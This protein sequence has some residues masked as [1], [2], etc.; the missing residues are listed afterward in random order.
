MSVSIV[1]PCYNES[2]II[3]D[4]VESF[5]QEVITKI[6]ESELIIVDDSSNDGS[7]QIL[8]DLQ[9][10]RPKLRVVKTDKNL[11]HGGA[12]LLGY[13]LSRYEYVFQTD[14]DRQFLVE[15][16]WKFYAARESFDFILGYRKTRADP[17]FR[18]ILSKFIFCFNLIVFSV[19]V[20][21]A[22]CAFRLMKK[23][24]LGDCL[25]RI[26]KNTLAPNIL[27]SILMKKSNSKML[28]VPLRHFRRSG[29]KA[30]F[31]FF[32]VISFALKGLFQLF[33]FRFGKSNFD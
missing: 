21:D 22:N 4:T 29:D 3:K 11:G 14:S 24:K 7:F 28:E 19:N 8:K 16:F 23:T 6:D 27:I 17:L 5:Y 12:I 10:K 32:R 31:P 2:G 25:K 20:K 9:A 26:N 1:I 30:G 15:D 18:V 13:N 33:C